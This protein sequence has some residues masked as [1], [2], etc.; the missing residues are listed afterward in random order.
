MKYCNPI[1]QQDFSDPDAIRVGEDF[2][3]VASSFNY[4]PGLPILHSKNLV[5]WEIINYIYDSLDERYD[6]VLH[7]KGSWA[8]AIRYN[9]G[10]F[11]CLIPMP[12]D[13]IYETHTKDIYGKWSPLKLVIKQRGLEDPCPIWT[14]GKCYCVVGFAKSRMGFNSCLGLYEMSNDLSECL[15]DT[16]TIIYDGHD[17]NPS[18]EGPKFNERNGYYYIM[19]PAGSVKGGWQVALRSKNIYGPYESK[20]VLMQGDTLINGPHQGALIDLGDDKWAFIHFRDMRPYGRIVHLEPVDWHND[21]P[22]CGHVNDALLAGTPVSECDY[23]IDKK[24]DYKIELDSD[25]KNK[26][27]ISFQTPANPKDGW[28]KMTDNGLIVNCVNGIKPLHLQENTYSEKVAYLSFNASIEFEL[29]LKNDLDEVGFF[30]SGKEYAYICVVRRNGKNYIEEREGSFDT[31]ENVISSIPYV[32][33]KVI[34]NIEAYNENTFDLMYRL[35][36][37]NN[38][39]KTLRKA[40]AGRWVGSRIGFYA[41]GNNNGGYAKALSFKVIEKQII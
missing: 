36:F 13:G 5:D 2:Y 4:M 20:I 19:A 15:S 21:W 34:F 29:N 7:G 16:Y 1:I 40:L 28:V 39:S 31:S 14:N 32:G 12:D 38:V 9:D 41:R 27:G 18:I 24:S 6:E 25:F 3:M 10:I 22:I 17:N 26:I 23:L 30:M 33:D 8:P 11:Y 35:G 37:D